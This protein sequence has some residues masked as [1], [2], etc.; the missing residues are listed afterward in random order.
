MFNLTPVHRRPQ[1]MTTP[2]A[3]SAKKD[4][5]I[6]PR[7]DTL[8]QGRDP[9]GA[10]L[11]PELAGTPVPEDARLLADLTRRCRENLSANDAA[12]TFL[13]E[14]GVA[15]ESVWTAYRIGSGNA[16][17]LEELD[18]ADRERLRALGLRPAKGA[19][20]LIGSGVVFP[21]FDP[22]EPETPVGLV[23]LRASANQ[24]Y[25]ATRPTGLGCT[26][27]IGEQAR[28]ILADSP[29]LTLRLTRLGARGVAL[30]ESPEVL[31][32]LA[33]WL[34]T[35]E[36]IACSYRSDR[37]AELAAA[38]QSLGVPHRA[39]KLDF[40][41][42]RTNATTLALLGIDKQNMLTQEPPP[43]PVTPRLIHELVEFARERVRQGEGL[44]LLKALKADDAGFLDAFE[45]G[46]LPADYAM[47]LSQ[48]DRR[49]LGGQR[50][51]NVIVLPARDASGV[52]VDLL[53]I[54]R[55][56]DRLQAGR[57]MPEPLGLL[58]SKIAK[59][60]DEITVVESFGALA[61]LFVSG[62]R[63]VLLLRGP[64]DAKHN[65]Q[66]LYESG[67]RSVRIA[68]RRSRDAEAIA[69]EMLKVGIAAEIT[70]RPKRLADMA[71][72][73]AAEA[74][75]MPPIKESVPTT[76]E[77]QEE[78]APIAPAVCEKDLSFIEGNGE[79]A[80][81]SPFDYPEKPA[82]LGHD[83]R[84]MRAKFK[85]G[86]A[87]YEIETAF[88][89]GS[90]LEVSLERNGVK[91]RDRFDLSKEAQ[92]KRFSVSAA[93]RTGVPYEA[94]E[95][96]LIL[97]LDAVRE[98]QAAV[99]DP[100]KKTAK[101]VASMMSDAERDD[102]MAMLRQPDLLQ[103]LVAAMTDLGWAG[104]DLLKELL[105]LVGVSRKLADPLHAA[106]R[107]PSGGGKTFAM[108]TLCTV[109]PPED[110]V[111]LSN[112]TQ[113][114]L[115]HQGDALRHKLVCLSE[116]DVLDR[117][118]I[119][120]LRV[121][122]SE[123]VLRQAGTIRDAATG[124]VVSDFR[125]AKGP[126]AFLT[127]TTRELDREILDRCYD[128][129]PDDSEAQTQ[130]IMEAQR[131]S[132][133]DPAG[134]ARRAALVT[135]LRNV[136]RLIEPLPVK[137]PFAGRIEFPSTSVR[138]RR[139]HQRFLRLIE[140]STL[141]HQHQRLK[142]G[143]CLL[144]D[145]QDFE[146]ARRLA[147]GSIGRAVDEL[148]RPAAAVLALARGQGLAAF[149]LNDLHERLPDWTRHRLYAALEE[150]NRLEFVTSERGRGK[151]RTYRLAAMGGRTRPEAGVRL[152]S[153]GEL[154]ASNNATTGFTPRAATG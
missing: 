2:R 61:T 123:G 25:F 48:E 75:H 27:D 62:V 54:W 144:A 70:G 154:S 8:H 119:V 88:D 85:A 146:T 152:R 133:F 87:L 102:A 36:I 77:V 134:E 98:I 94:I 124:V 153:M 38:L 145:M 21:T 81:T 93:V 110:L 64:E 34:K 96:H 86:D 57:L 20:P 89:V 106:L 105:F 46:H 97:L 109:T 122:L 66:R 47:A 141:L 111:R 7:P 136:Q 131:R 150:L 65:A 115:I 72:G 68:F 28:V 84:M 63:N 11:M 112:L 9:G 19:S 90:K 35:R 138:L 5:S 44:E 60:F 147:A 29:L 142:D 32:S 121:L 139:E 43:A 49:S 15:D 10:A 117:E 78:P 148:S 83:P 1:T 100:A 30:C 91:A 137:I 18:D 143:G 58:G 16:A 127:S 40:E 31:F 56:G 92:R 132:K 118:V 80:V 116:S 52:A 39:M 23:R 22:R 4:V 99:L 45:I 69:A 104:E 74:P 71:K 125:E 59:A 126:V 108:E 79:A 130:R 95:G 17:M 41:L 120:Q 73:D 12:K 50:L 51:G 114:A 113:A 140:A 13:R 82:L 37:L 14:Q 151:V 67:V 107:S 103:A 129:T 135:R 101:P 76:P 6:S 24:H 53:S 149:S 26:P 3:H 128:L 42:E 55:D 33:D